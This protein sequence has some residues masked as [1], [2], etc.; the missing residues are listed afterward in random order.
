VDKQRLDQ[1]FS[2]VRDLE[3][4]IARLEEEPPNLVA[5]QRPMAPGAL[6]DIDGRPQMKE[7]SRAMSDLVT[8]AY[9]CDMTRVLSY[10]YSQPVSD[11]LF[12]DTTAG[13]HQ[14]T[15]DETDEMPQVN[16][17]VISI[18]ADLAYLIESL[19]NIPEGDGTILDN[20]IIMATTDVSYGRTHQI[21]EYP[22]IIAGTGCG[23]LKTG[24]HYRSGTKENTSLVSYS[25]INAM[26]ATISEFGGEAGRVTSGLS[27]IE[28]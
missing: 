4:R 21:D 11:V 28:S 1:H 15:H 10:W 17:I 5:C 8:M 24:F 9:A 22:I 20:S 7:R 18:M 14:L 27:V 19:K 25:L 13:H 23:T 6:E 3:L 2:A 26:G 12:P 16:Q